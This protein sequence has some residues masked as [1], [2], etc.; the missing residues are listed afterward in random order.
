MSQ[1]HSQ[2]GNMAEQLGNERLPT[3]STPGL[4]ERFPPPLEPEANGSLVTPRHYWRL[5]TDPRLSPMGMATAQP[6][7]STEA[8]LSLIH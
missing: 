6:S 7:I 8:F 1:G 5:S 2:P 3:H 4:G